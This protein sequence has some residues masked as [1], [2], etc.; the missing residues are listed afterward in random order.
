M[1]SIWR[2]HNIFVCHIQGRWCSFSEF[3]HATDCYLANQVVY[4]CFINSWFDHLS[5]ELD[6]RTT[7]ETARIAI[8]I[9]KTGKGIGKKARGHSCDLK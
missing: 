3:L 1:R 8:G 4:M 6:Q 2:P 7:R 9:G 5:L